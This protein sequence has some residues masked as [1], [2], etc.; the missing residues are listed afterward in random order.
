MTLFT[1][2][3][4][5]HQA[6]DTLGT[7]VAAHDAQ[8]GGHGAEA[9]DN[10]FAELLHH[11]YDSNELEL[12][13]IG[14]IELPQFAPVDVGGVMIDFSITK[15][16]VFLWLAALD[17]HRPYDENI[18]PHPHKPADVIVPPYLPDIPDVRKDLALYYDEIARLDLG[19]GICFAYQG[20]IRRFLRP[21]RRIL[22]FA[23]SRRHMN[24]GR[25]SHRFDHGDPPPRGKVAEALIG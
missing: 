24:E 4:Q 7:S 13:F 2:Y 25:I 5:E 18:I 15:H 6:A 9:G 17:P 16:V 20:L 22:L 8:A 14:H 10:L 1:N 3:T 21:R 19:A 23:R 11:V 12:P